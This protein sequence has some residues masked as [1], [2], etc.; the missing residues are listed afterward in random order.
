[1][2]QNLG[3]KSDAASSQESPATGIQFQFELSK[4][5]GA[6]VEVAHGVWWIRLPIDSSLDFVNVYALRDGNRLTLVDVGVN[7]ESSIKVLDAALAAPPLAQLPL[8]RVIVTHFHPDHIGAAGVLAQRGIELWM[9]RTCWLSCKLLLQ[10]AAS[11]PKTPEVEFMRRAGLSGIE[12]EA[13]KRQ[14]PHR[15]QKQVAT[16]PEDFV[17]LSDGQQL[18]IGDRNWKVVVGNGHAAEHLTLWC[19]DLAIVGDQVLPSISSNLTIPF[20]EPEGDLVAEWLLSC[21]KLLTVA[22]NQILGLPGHQ[23]PFT[24]LENRL[25]QIQ[26][27]MEGAMER[28][29]KILVRPSSAL[30]CMEQFHN[31]SLTFDQRKQMLPEIVGFLNHLYRKGEV[32]RRLSPQGTFVYTRKRNTLMEFSTSHPTKEDKMN[33]P[34]LP[35]NTPSTAVSS[36]PEALESSAPA[37]PISDTSTVV[38]STQH[39][40]QAASQSTAPM[41]KSSWLQPK[42]WFAAFTLAGILGACYAYRDQLQVWGNESLEQLS[43]NELF[44]KP[45]SSRKGLDTTVMPVQVMTL[46]NLT[47]TELPRRFTGVIKPRRA[48]EIGFNRVGTMDEILVERGQR[49][50][51]DAV[52]AKLNIASLQANMKAV[53]AQYKAATA[54][55]EEMISGPRSQTVDSARNQLDAAKAELELAKT[56]LGRAERLVSIGAVSKQ[57]VDNAQTLVKAKQEAVNAAENTF[58]ELKEG[59]RTEQIRAQRAVLNELEAAQEQMK[60]QLDESVI[61]APFAAAVSER[62]LDPGTVCSPG[63]PV[64]RLIELV[65]P[66]VWIGLPPEYSAA[67]NQSKTYSIKVNGQSFDARLK[68]VLPELD[69]GT[70]TNTVVFELATSDSNSIFGQVAEIELS[71]P[72]RES[73][74][75]LPMSAIVKG[76]HGLWGVLVLEKDPE[77]GHSKLLKQ[78]LEVVHVDSDRVYARGTIADGEQ[79]VATGLHRLTPGQVVRALGT[80]AGQQAG[81]SDDAKLR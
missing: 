27:N 40:S 63:V 78:E 20:T 44:E 9:S 72:I 16:L 80:D 73:G 65:S 35:A 68:S 28:L 61:R 70:R 8:K 5:V 46:K 10:T 1:M 2:Q 22:N 50:E 19:D 48:S 66:E 42:R 81:V 47:S 59:T 43:Q 75:W 29:S 67:M 23:R 62:F 7:S 64:V 71:R 76:D 41:K 38:A 30:E 11:A 4:Q 36:V 31:R 37:L 12:L 32:E 17:P 58:N 51:K 21:Q 49:V 13:Y 60:V 52:L 54:R 74:F 26:S 39:V 3:S 79:V 24:G 77:S 53:Q 45:Q 34:M 15:Y 69:S 25:V 55:L 57:E 56:S 33:T 14:P 6:P 18:T